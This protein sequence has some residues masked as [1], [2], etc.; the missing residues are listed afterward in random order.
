MVTAVKVQIQGSCYRVPVVPDYLTGE[1]LDP[2]QKNCTLAR[3]ERK[4]ESLDEG[5]SKKLSQVSEQF[6][7]FICL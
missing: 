5:E 2:V 6:F 4:A 7:V 1:G 3:S